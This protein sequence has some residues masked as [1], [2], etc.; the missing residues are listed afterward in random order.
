MEILV[1]DI[2]RQFKERVSSGRKLTADAVEAAA[3][4]RVWSG[5]QAQELGLVDQLGGFEEAIMDAKT[6]LG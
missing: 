2:Y 1:D 4:G 5:R 6:A 3:Q